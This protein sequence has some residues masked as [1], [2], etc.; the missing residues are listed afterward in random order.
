MSYTG[1]KS[2]FNRLAPYTG[3][4]DRNNEEQSVRVCALHHELTFDEIMLQYGGQ[5]KARYGVTEE[6]QQDLFLR[7]KSTPWQIAWPQHLCMPRGVA[8]IFKKKY[9]GIDELKRQ[10]P[11]VGKVLRLQNGSMHLYYMVTKKQSQEKASYKDLW[12]TLLELRHQLVMKLTIPKIGCG[13]DSL[14]WRT[15]R[16]MKETIFQY[17]GI[18]IRVCSYQNKAREY[19]R[20]TVDCHFF[21]T[22]HCSRGSSCRF[23]HD[24][25]KCAPGR[26]ETKEGTV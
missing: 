12:D 7:R 25:T 18:S 17:T 23:L 4:H 16:N 21:L 8:A 26:I 20:R 10:Q 15:M 1:S 3:D 6:V 24:L 5:R 19:R 22:S 9:G 11:S 14:N 2:H 13:L